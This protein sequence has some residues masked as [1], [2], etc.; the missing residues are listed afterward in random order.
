MKNPFKCCCR[1]KA[2]RV[3]PTETI[4]PVRGTYK[5]LPGD[6]SEIVQNG[7]GIHH[8]VS[9]VVKEDIDS[10]DRMQILVKKFFVKKI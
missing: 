8:S 2:V 5:G 4:E 9:N 6:N 3:I 7:N 10:K 1:K